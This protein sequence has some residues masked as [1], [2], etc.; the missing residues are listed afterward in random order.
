MDEVLRELHCEARMPNVMRLGKITEEDMKT[1]STRPRPL[2]V[3]LTIELSKNDILEKAKD[4]RKTKHKNLFIVQDLTP[5][6]RAQRKVLVA[7]RDQ[8]IKDGEDLI[9]V[10]GKILPRR[11]KRERK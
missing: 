10:N 3:V 4:L 6:E 8:R 11:E 9:I 2:K 5:N 7:E 1:P